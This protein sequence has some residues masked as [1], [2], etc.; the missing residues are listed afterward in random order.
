MDG[1]RLK[2]IFISSGFALVLLVILL[3]RLPSLFEPF[4]YADEG[5]YLTLGQAV[6]KGLVLY[7]DIH[8]N[9]P[10][11]LYLI[12]ALAGSFPLYRLIHFLWSFTTIFAFYKLAQLVFNK[13]NKWAILLPTTVFAIL[14]SLQTC[15]AL[16]SACIIF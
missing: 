6:R 3:L 1:N 7:R 2:K 8:D 13:N 9:K 15:L 12:A 16:G 11:M 4:T 14:T 5:I 10:P